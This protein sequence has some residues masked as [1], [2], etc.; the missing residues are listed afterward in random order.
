MELLMDFPSYEIPVYI[1]WYFSEVTRLGPGQNRS[2]RIFKDNEPYSNPILPP[3][4]DCDEM[5]ASEIRV[6]NKT[7]FS[8]VPTNVSTLPPLINAMEI[9]RIGEFQ[10]TDGT[11][12]KDGKRDMHLLHMSR[13]FSV[14]VFVFVF[15]KNINHLF[16][17]STQLF[18]PSLW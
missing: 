15:E 16:C 13:V 6:S 11:N 4:G 7:I 8:L 18:F 3:Y 12:K 17:F 5:W 10:L 2:F 14:F 9:F 1:N